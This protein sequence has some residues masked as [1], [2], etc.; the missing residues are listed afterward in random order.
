MPEF[1]EIVGAPLSPEQKM[2]TDQEMKEQ[3]EKSAKNAGVVIIDLNPYVQH[4]KNDARQGFYR[5]ESYYHLPND[6]NLGRRAAKETK[7]AE[8][9]A[10]EKQIA[11]KVTK[12]IDFVSYDNGFV[13]SFLRVG[14]KAVQL[15]VMAH[16]LVAL[17]NKHGYSIEY[18]V[19]EFI[20]AEA[21]RLKKKAVKDAKKAAEENTENWMGPIQFFVPEISTN[22]KLDED[23]TFEL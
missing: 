21:Q 2:P 22:L 1:N 23:W 7:F 19:T 11:L 10:T 20:K 13:K 4:V 16:K 3:M 5:R 6:G 12:P 17:D 15:D 14:L 9:L 18:A 8:L